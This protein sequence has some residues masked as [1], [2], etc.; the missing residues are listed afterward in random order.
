M[1]TDPNSTA[2]KA[3]FLFTRGNEWSR[4]PIDVNNIYRKITNRVS[5]LEDYPEKTCGGDS[6]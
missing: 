1:T 5:A 4:M 2:Q 6:H 3:V